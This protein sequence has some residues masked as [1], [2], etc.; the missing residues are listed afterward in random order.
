MIIDLHAIYLIMM[1]KYLDEIMIPGLLARRFATAAV[2]V[3]GGY[4]AKQVGHSMHREVSRFEDPVL[5]VALP[6]AIIKENVGLAAPP[7]KFDCPNR[8]KLEEN[9][10]N[11][12]FFDSRTVPPVNHEL[13]RRGTRLTKE[14]LTALQRDL[15]HSKQMSIWNPVHQKVR[16]YH[17]AT[18]NQEAI[19]DSFTMAGEHEGAFMHNCIKNAFHV[20]ASVYEAIVAPLESAVRGGPSMNPGDF[21]E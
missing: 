21:D 13:E 15:D 11:V 9:C 4:A 1:V 20:K 19:A 5:L 8:A 12:S 7:A 10:A 14:S 3:A 2:G 18:D 17:I 6:V 16:D